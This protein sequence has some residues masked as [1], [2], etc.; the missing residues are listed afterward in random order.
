MKNRGDEQG[1]SSVAFADGL[2]DFLSPRSF[3]VIGVSG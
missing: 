2:D 1:M 3:A